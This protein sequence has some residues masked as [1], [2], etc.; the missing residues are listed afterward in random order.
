MS[1]DGGWESSSVTELEHDTEADKLFELAMAEEK[2]GKRVI[3]SVVIGGRN[4]SGIIN[5]YD[6]SDGN[7]IAFGFLVAPGISVKWRGRRCNARVEEISPTVFVVSDENTPL[8][9]DII[10]KDVC[11]L[12]GGHSDAPNC[13][14]CHKRP[15]TCED[16]DGHNQC[17]DPCHGVA[18]PDDAA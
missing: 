12:C 10:E 1:K 13:P 16:G 15:C 6:R 14:D 3:G 17:P 18:K 5:S 11:V 7:R 2:S 9:V 4:L 8:R